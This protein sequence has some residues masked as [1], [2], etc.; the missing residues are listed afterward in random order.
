MQK[1]TFQNLIEQYQANEITEYEIYKNLA[2]NTK[3]KKNSKILRQIAEDEL[4]HYK[5]WKNITGKDIAP[6]RGKIWL[7]V[8]MAKLF[9]LTFTLK[10]MEKGEDSA[11]TNYSQLKGKV[12]AIE[13]IAKDEG[14][15]EQLLLELLDEERLQYVGSIVLGLN[16]AL[17]EL[18]GSLAGLTLALGNSRLIA[19]TGVII[20]VAAAMSMAASEFLSTKAEES[21]KHPLKSSVYTGI[22]YIFTVWALVLPYLILKNPLLSLTCMLI[23]GILIIA[24]F[25]YYLSV[26]LDK[27]FRRSFFEMVF[28][29]LGVA[30]I[31]FGIGYFVRTFLGVEV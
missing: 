3:S 27:P 30:G 17:V 11:Q 16:D 7:Y 22:A 6:D 23:I 25:N 15:H 10:L 21:G 31:S 1:S 24:F 29:S 26:A 14:K 13:R 4:R 20:G 9:G 12:K 2:E 8:T 5:E 19:L 18:T 28:V